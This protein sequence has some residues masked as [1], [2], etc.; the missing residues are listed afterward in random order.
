MLKKR[1]LKPG[2]KIPLY[3]DECVK[4]MFCNPDRLEPI[5]LLL[6]N[7]LQVKYEDLE[8]RI[9]LAPTK[10]PTGTI[11]RKKTER[12]IVVYIKNEPRDKVIIEVNIRDSYYDTIINRN[13]HYLNEVASHGL[14]EGESYDNIEPTFLINFNNFYVDGFHK[15]VFD[16]YYWMNEEG[17]ILTTKERILNVNT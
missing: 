3:F 12:D 11:G 17:Y 16:Y 7:V 5:T 8:G 4:L 10:V 9:E 2:E 15:K 6:S 14:L 13:I 1:E